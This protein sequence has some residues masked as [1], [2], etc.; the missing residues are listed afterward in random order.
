MMSS[1]FRPNLSQDG[2]RENSLV[3]LV[4]F[5]PTGLTTCSYRITV[6]RHRPIGPSAQSAT[7]QTAY[8]WSFASKSSR[9]DADALEA[10]REAVGKATYGCDGRLWTDSSSSST[11]PATG[12][13]G[14]GRVHGPTLPSASDLVLARETAAE[15]RDAD[16]KN[17][18]KRA[19]VEALERVED[20][21]GPKEVGREGMLEKKRARREA[22]RAMRDKGDDGF[23]ADERTL[24]G[25]GDIFKEQCVP[26]PS[27]PCRHCDTLPADVVWFARV[28]RRDVTRLRFEEKRGAGR[29][30]NMSAARERTNAMREKD[31]MDTDLADNALDITWSSFISLAPSDSR[32]GGTFVSPLQSTLCKTI[33]DGNW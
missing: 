12:P 4:A 16:R 23:E 13:S 29:E 10:A 25:G 5:R 3:R 28:A 32:K 21:I 17:D 7:P 18:R 26:S 27:P 11:A 24:L 8:K 15:V 19:R 2:T 14:S 6:R 1:L 22:D 33:C 20:M 31:K 30:E 9:T